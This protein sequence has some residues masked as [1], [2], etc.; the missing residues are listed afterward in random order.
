MSTFLFYVEPYP[1]RN[2]FIH[3]RAILDNFAGS[4][5]N[6]KTEHS[7]YIYGNKETLNEY[8]KRHENWEK[9]FILPTKQ[10]NNFFK[11]CMLGW[12]Q[13]GIE[14]WE[15]LMEDSELSRQYVK[16]IKQ[17]HRRKSFDYIV[18]WGTNFAVKRAAKELEIGFIDMEL[19]CSRT[20]FL[21]SLVADPWGVNGSSSLSKSDISDFQNIPSSNA[22]NDFLFSGGINSLAYESK[23]A[24]L[25]VS[26]ILNKIG[27][28]KMALISLQLYDDANQVHYSPFESVKAVLQRILPVL[29]KEGYVCLIKEHPASNL[30]RGSENANLEAKLYALDFENVVWL[31]YKDKDIQNSTLFRIA[32]VVI[33]VNSSSGFEALFYEKPVVVLGDAVYKTANVFPTLEDYLKGNFDYEVYKTNIGKIRNFFLNYYL[34][35]HEQANDSRFFFPY[36]KFIGDMS[37]K[38]MSVKEIINSYYQR[39]KNEN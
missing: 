36:L 31:T 13:G 24:Y 15:E 20:P 3:F 22:E 33:T 39:G 28:K 7:F 8:K 6:N 32:D 19:G 29:S 35:S 11:S 1:I 9:H 18:C 17:I 38:N 16:V 25:D 37:L 21:N 10:E 26:Q 23:F 30:R 14:K 5:D 12:D 4:L 34:F 2:T 27:E